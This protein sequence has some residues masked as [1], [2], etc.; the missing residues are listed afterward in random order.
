MNSILAC[1]FHMQ[2]KARRSPYELAIA[3]SPRMNFQ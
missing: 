3:A 1:E 2:Y